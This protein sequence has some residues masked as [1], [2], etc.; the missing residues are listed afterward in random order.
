MAVIA[1]LIA[2]TPLKL[3]YLIEQDGEE[4]T[5]V[6]LSA[7]TLL[8]DCIAGALKEMPGI[9]S[10]EEGNDT[11][12]ARLRMLGEGA[13]DGPFGTNLTNHPHA[14][15]KITPRGGTLGNAPQVDADADI[16]NPLRD[17]V[18]VTMPTAFCTAILEIEFQHTITR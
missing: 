17:Q 6:T 2:Q 5:G 12:R 4:G 13:I 15:C 8:E 7:A 10:D 14:T 9:G 1:T 16:V 18:A 3:R 11:A